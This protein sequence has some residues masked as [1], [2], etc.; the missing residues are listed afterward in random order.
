MAATASA[1]NA[2]LFSGWP[3]DHA[4]QASAH[5]ILDQDSY[6]RCRLQMRCNDAVLFRMF[7]ARV[8]S[9][10][11]EYDSGRN[12]SMCTDTT[13]S[14]RAAQARY[15]ALCQALAAAL[16]VDIVALTGTRT[17][18]SVAA[19]GDAA[20]R[21]MQIMPDVAVYLGP[22]TAPFGTGVP[23]LDARDDLPVPTLCLACSD[24][25]DMIA[26]MEFTRLSLYR[27]IGVR[28]LWS[29]TSTEVIIYDLQSEDGPFSMA[30]ERSSL[31]L[32]DVRSK[33]LL[34]LLRVFE[35]NCGGTAGQPY[36]EPLLASLRTAGG[37]QLPA[38]RRRRQT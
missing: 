14:Q 31:T 30:P 10:T 22:D 15:S 4:R 13:P 17:R 35:D 32:V 33:D 27:E 9:C 25:D 8:V 7:L 24:D 23:P 5:A 29:F 11:M 3:T 34:E 26:G 38:P 2:G 20:P 16:D 21:D 36:P 12:W 37:L 28:E 1:P 6:G 18:V 19:H